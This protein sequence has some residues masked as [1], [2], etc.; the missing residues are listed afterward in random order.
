[1]ALNSTSRPSIQGKVLVRLPATFTA[2]GGLTVEK[3]GGVWTLSPDFSLLTELATLLTPGSK[4]IWVWDPVTDTYN[5]MTLAALG[6]SLFT[7]TSVTSNT[8][9]TGAFT[10]AS[11]A[12]KLWPVGGTVVISSDADPSVDYMT[13][14]VT[15]YSAAG[16]LVV[17]VPTGGNHG[18][19][20][21]TD[22]T[23]S[24]SGVTG[25]TGTAATIAAG[26]T[27]TLA[28]GSSATAANSGTSSAAVL[29]FGIPRGAT[30]AIGYTFSTTTTDSD[31]G[32]GV[33]RFNNPT[34]ASVT[35]IYFDN[36]DA[37]GNTATAWLD[38]FDDS[39]NTAKGKLTFTDVTAPAV[40]MVFPV[41]GSVVDGTGYRKVT[42]TAPTLGATLFTNARRLAVVFSPAGD[43][44]A[45]G[46]GTITGLT[47]HGVT[48]AS[49][50]SAITASV[51]LGANEFLVGAAGAD[52][53]AKTVAQVAALLSAP[54]VTVYTTGSG[55]YTTPSGA[56]HLIV[57][58]VGGGG[59]GGASG[60]TPGTAT[61]GG[62]TT[63]GT[64][65]LTANGGSAGTTTNTEA[66]G[67]TATGGDINIT[68]GN[69]AASY[70][71]NVI[72]AVGGT[73]VYGGPG[74]GG[75]INKAAGA[76][77]T[78]PGSGGGGAGAATSVAL[79]G[80]GAAG[81]YVRKLITTPSATYAYAVG[82]AGVGGTLGTSGGAGGNGAAGLITVT[83]YFQ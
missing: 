83:A 44:G 70:S 26:T 56:K 10:F 24:L 71:P 52:P 42:V 82:A 57:E 22:W 63:F 25:A 41:T 16:S 27:T 76:N 18:S 20:A 58:A 61:A 23:I 51:V 54:Q 30:P 45:D 59:G 29:D 72:G 7:G 38:S 28:E 5:V 67:G 2:T 19:G 55:T 81:G 33:V 73:S 43:K 75:T 39:T 79:L 69:G 13:A 8:I 31:P 66:A 11:Q 12:G 4:D 48:I 80:G 60:S 40:K 14:T 74:Q 3:A 37:D 1:M 9:G 68:G 46:A 47:N 78:A 36:A 65:L 17:D 77:A 6:A 15:S 53:Q 34:P 64:A 62:N 35:A 49:A 21:H 50:A 32:A